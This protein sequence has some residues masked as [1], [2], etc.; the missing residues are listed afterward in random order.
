MTV[1]RA[2]VTGVI[3]GA[4]ADPS[5]AV[6]VAAHLSL[7]NPNTGLARTAITDQG[8]NYRFLQVP[9][10]QDYVVEVEASG[11]Q[12]GRAER[13]Q[14]ASE[15][16]LSRGFS[17]P[18]GTAAQSVEVSAAVMQVETTSTQRDILD[19]QKMTALPLNGRSYLDLL[20]LQA[21]VVRILW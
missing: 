13:Y 3:L 18:V 17:A 4:V 2:D 21:G 7:R 14:S 12:K 9:V 8:G 5:G 10:G 11:F 6:I 19:N 20:G 16:E 15:S 1:A